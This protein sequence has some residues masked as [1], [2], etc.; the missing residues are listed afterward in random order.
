MHSIASVLVPPVLSAQRSLLVH[1]SVCPLK[2]AAVRRQFPPSMQCLCNMAAASCELCSL[3]LQSTQNSILHTPDFLF[4][5]QQRGFAAAG[6]VTRVDPA[7]IEH[8][9]GIER[10][11]RTAAVLV[12]P[13]S[14]VALALQSSAGALA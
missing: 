4:Q 8:A 5:H 3:L 11:G 2:H 10:C 6:T 12:V 1:L 7:D 13:C 9:T 14:S